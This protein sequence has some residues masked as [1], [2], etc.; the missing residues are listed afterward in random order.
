MEIV[1][2]E[3]V[4]TRSHEALTSLVVHYEFDLQLQEKLLSRINWLIDEGIIEIR[5]K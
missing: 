5:K 1:G 3:V 2:N 4:E